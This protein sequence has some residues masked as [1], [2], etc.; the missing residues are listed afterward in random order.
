[1]DAW[2]AERESLMDDMA[3]KHARSI[4]GTEWAI[5]LAK[6]APMGGCHRAALDTAERA[7]RAWIRSREALEDHEYERDRPHI[8]AHRRMVEDM[9]LDTAMAR[10]DHLLGPEWLGD[11]K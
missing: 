4:R 2:T 8:E 10:M 9:I 11:G 7:T 5:T 6:V 3:E 1:M